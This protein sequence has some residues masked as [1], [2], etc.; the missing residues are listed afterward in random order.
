M[1]MTEDSDTMTETDGEVA[2]ENTNKYIMTE[3]DAKNI[4]EIMINNMMPEL[5]NIEGRIESLENITSKEMTENRS[6]E[7]EDI[8]Y[9]ETLK[10][11][12]RIKELSSYIKNRSK[13]EDT[14][15]SSEE[16]EEEEELTG[17]RRNDMTKTE[18]EECLQW[19]EEFPRMKADAMK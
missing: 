10:I 14:D 13:K 17:A 16:E 19:L 6:K 15:Q 3:E 5:R 12:D 2:D 9:Q 7:A 1:M 4:A 8:L 18:E 11:R